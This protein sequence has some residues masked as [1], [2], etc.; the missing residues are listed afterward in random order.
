MKT[1]SR[2]APV[3]GPSGRG[4]MEIGSHDHLV[5]GVLSQEPANGVSRHLACEEG[6]ASGGENVGGGG[7]RRP[8]AW[9]AGAGSHEKASYPQGQ[10]PPP[11]SQQ[12]C[13]SGGTLNAVDME[14][15][16]NLVAFSAS[17]GSLLPASAS[18]AGPESQPCTAQLYEKF[19]REMAAA[20]GRADKGERCPPEDI[21]TLQTALSQ[22][23][24]GHKPPN[25]DCDGPD[26]PD[27]L[28][29]LEKKIRLAGD[30][31]Q[32]KT[33]CKMS[34][35]LQ[36]HPHQPHHQPSQH[37]HPP[38]PNGASGGCGQGAPPP[39]QALGEKPPALVRCPPPPI[40][41][42][43]SVLSIAK[44]KN[45]SLETAIA[46]EALTQLSATI[47]QSG[48]PPTEAS[49]NHPQQQQYAPHHPSMHPQH[50]ARLMPSSP[51]PLSSSSSS[52]SQMQQQ[53]VRP[54]VDP[55]QDSRSWEQQQ[56]QQQQHRPQ[57]QGEAP[58]VMIPH[59][60]PSQ[61]SPSVSP[62]A[63]PPHPQDG[64]RSPLPQQWQQ[65]QQGPRGGSP[66][67]PWMGPMNPESQPQFAPR[68]G[69]GGD[70]MSE[71]KQLL[72]DA[73]GKYVNAGFRFPGPQPPPNNHDMAAAGGP[74]P[75]MPTIKQEVDG[76]EYLNSAMA[77]YVMMN[78]QQHPQQYPGS[79]LSPAALSIRH[80]T[81]A[82]LQQHLH[83]KRNLFSNPLSPGQR[84]PMAC[85]NLRKWW[86]QMSPDMP[87]MMPIKQEPKEPKKRTPQS[88]PLTKLGPPLPK[89]KQ[90]VIKKVKQKASQPTFLP[91]SQIVAQKAKAQSLAA[92]CLP[93]MGPA[94]VSAFPF[95]NPSQAVAAPVAPAQSQE[96]ILNGCSVVPSLAYGGIAA[97]T[98]P[99]SSSVPLPVATPVAPRDDSA[100][101][102]S[103]SGGPAASGALAP[104]LTSTHQTSAQSAPLLTG[105]SS[106]DPKF[107]DLIRQFEEE[108]GETPAASSDASMSASSAA[109]PNP[110][111]AQA[112][113]SGQPEAAE[114][115]Q[116][117]NSGLAKPTSP[118]A[119]QPRA[120]SA[121]PQAMEV[122]G[123]QTEAGVA[124]EGALSASTQSPAVSQTHQQGELSLSAAGPPAPISLD[125]LL[126]LPP[127]QQQQQCHM[128]QD[129]F[130]TPGSPASK[131]VKIESSGGLTV[132]STTSC[133]T[134]GTEEDTPTKDPMTPSLKGFLESPLRYLDTP[135]KNVLDTPA[136]DSQAEFPVCDCVEHIQEKDEG[137]Y[138][139]H[140]GAGPTVASIR[141]LME[142]RYGE[143]GE[144]IR[145]E[146]VVYTGREGK[147][148]LGCPIAK[149]VIRRSGEKE[150]LL[151]LVRHR[152]GHHCANAVIIILIMAWEGV[153]RLF[154]DKLYKEIAQ[155]L[156]KY[157]NPTSRR[158][159][160][161]DD[162][163]CA[164]QG[165][166]SETCGAS[167]SFGC[168]WSMYFNGC[169]Y[170]RSKVPRKF[171]LQGEHPED[172]E[173]LRE[174][175]QGLATE[176]APLYKQLAPQAYSNQCQHED[177]AIDCRLGLKEG[178]PFSGV[179]ACM[180]FCAHA[181]KDQHNLHNGCTVVCTLTKED[182]RTVGELPA[183]E[184]LHVLPLYKVS[185]A[186]EF[187]SVENQR[188]K[189]ETGAI[190]VLNNFRREVRKLPEP[191][192]S[193]RQR[194]LEAK[195]AAMEKKKGTKTPA[196][197]PEKTIKT[198]TIHR[199]SPHLQQGN[200]AIPKQEMKPNIKKEP[201]DRYHSFN[202]ALPPGYPAPGN[203]QAAEP[204][205]GMNNAYP[206]P[207]YYARGGLPSNS[208]T[209]A[210]APVNGFHPNLPAL[211]YGY[212]NYPPKALF[213]PELMGYEG[214]SGSWPN[215]AAG[216][217]GAASFDQ[218]PDV[219]SLQARLG[220][221]E[222]PALR[223]YVTPSNTPQPHGRP[224]HTPTP[225]PEPR[226]ATPVIKQEPM[227]VPVYGNCRPDAGSQSCPGTPSTTPQPPESWPS[228]RP[229]GLMSKGWEGP[230]RPGAADSPFTPD[231]QMLHQ[232]PTHHPQHA[233]PQQQ[234]QHQQQ[235]QQQW[236]HFHGHNTPMASPAPSPSP[237]LKQG[238]S[239]APSPHPTT[240]RHW[241][242]PSPSGQ[243]K[244][245]PAGFSPA[246]K[247]EN[248]AGGYPDKM[249]SRGSTPLGLQEKAWRSGGGSAAGN[250]PSPAPEGRLFPDALQRPDAQGCWTPCKS[251]SE[252]ESQGERDLDD[253]GVWSDSEHNFLD[254]NI[255]GVAVAPAHGSVLIECA[256]RELHATTP[257]KRPDRTHPSRISLVF[258]QHK[259]LNQPCHG[260]ALWEAKMKLLAERARQRQ[261]EAI[262][263]GLPPEDIKVFGK[264]R[265]WASGA[266][267]PSPGPA[268][269]KREGVATRLAPTLN[270]SS[271]ITVSS[272]AYTQLTG[273]YSRLV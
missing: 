91:Q 106:L 150:K 12:E 21:N 34:E 169:K 107:E 272:Y 248:P 46:L 247:L 23:R 35:A 273:P 200:K 178:R 144:A 173:V 135:T 244:A 6:D 27:Y 84:A 60:H 75:R 259:N 206:Y 2:V 223:G 127:Q 65:Q 112:E 120:P 108:F 240:P 83:H 146:K 37:P 7:G 201:V 167:F 211:P 121:G 123:Q 160:L 78:G 257:L 164:C 68:G 128:L 85:Q 62:F 184:Q 114:P 171:R 99:P 179:T 196:E 215:G 145:I 230:H 96:S 8:Q 29:W 210:A 17:A 226:R 205:G 11:Q 245:W 54:G 198:E 266:A 195:K 207:G 38:Q 125:A 24:H 88:S 104:G 189:M 177:E 163:T 18:S 225:P 98:A 209:P 116:D 48:V 9:G 58:R 235:Q 238:F 42:S 82:A 250:T 202:G 258:Y 142:A 73:S 86:P 159:G 182:N 237:S 59:H 228:H 63:G 156:T 89:P 214:R 176:V 70:P 243:P 50:G 227:D 143:K 174:N 268:K 25:C 52:S 13:W 53:A 105:L 267:S 256:R 236:N 253:D 241:E 129:P 220:H 172:E 229:N 47:P 16:R 33:H 199:G 153:P 101:S 242:S 14:D 222:D 124:S 157:G 118:P 188:R 233:Y 165:K 137:P 166:D 224:S 190:H 261:E 57:S 30:S 131:R 140:L 154:A 158:C 193:C 40:P 148:S 269:D 219:Q 194:R 170:A 55:Q 136:K 119:E 139:N 251:E 265:K 151:C 138:Y 216:A 43:P 10:A 191:A 103:S 231:K 187:G 186:D 64:T 115:Q 80:S 122:G 26:C 95:P 208:Q 51:A 197:T 5:D 117:A 94:S 81:Q 152:A 87:P 155:T 254:P 69:G 221:A 113:G 133:L 72:G 130:A 239:P 218:K 97:G 246:V 109:A 263:L 110:P 45:I 44:E 260:L 100:T 181:H 217:A 41:C 126:G 74:H 161:N 39:G 15:A 185:N 192:K 79:P 204:Y 252:A 175:F 22:A 180:D 66:R 36:S 20:A 264:K 28:E 249:L 93:G 77:R 76:G 3:H 141:D 32:G 213:P 132:I 19:N 232:N 183:D 149:W 4:Q 212:C 270:T 102:G 90:I 203:G 255:G 49:M 92:Q 147:S 111:H 67:T 31:Q 56:Q 168:S 271:L 71:L 262:L 234:Q 162:R 1:V 61:Y 134:P